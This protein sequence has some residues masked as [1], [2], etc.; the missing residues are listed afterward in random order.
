MPAAMGLIEKMFETGAVRMGPSRHD[1][2]RQV[3][4]FD[5]AA[6]GRLGAVRKTELE[7]FRWLHGSWTY[8]NPV[9][10]TRLS[11]E[12]CDVGRAVFAPSA[13]GAWICTVA[14]DG[15]QI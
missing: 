9:P 12:Y 1:P 3:A 14:P 4:T 13:D 2:S 6:V 10:A 5:L 7:R 8:E 15:R 11:P